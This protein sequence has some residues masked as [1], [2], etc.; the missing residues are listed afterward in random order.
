METIGIHRTVC[1]SRVITRDMYRWG[2]IMTSFLKKVLS[3]TRQGSSVKEEF[4]KTPSNMATPTPVSR[5]LTDH[6][7]VCH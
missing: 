6:V 4:G 3:E 5:V 7:I 1:I 2:R